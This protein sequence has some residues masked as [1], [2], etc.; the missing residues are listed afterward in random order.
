MFKNPA[1]QFPDAGS[2]K[3][4]YNMFNHENFLNSC[5]HFGPTVTIAIERKAI[6]L[7]RNSH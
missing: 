2:T 6:S 3:M 7:T 1:T 4:S 5:P